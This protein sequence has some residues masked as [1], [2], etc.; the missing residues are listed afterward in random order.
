[1][2]MPSLFVSHGSPLLLL[3]PCPARDFLLGAG[4]ALPKPSAVLCVSAHWCSAGPAVTGAE[5]PQQIYDFR[6]F[7]QVLYEQTYAARG[8]AALAGDI[9]QLLQSSGF[10]TATDRHRGL[11]HGA[12]VPL[13]LMYPDASVPVL[14]LS[15]QP[16]RDPAWHLQLGRAL[17]PLRD[18]G[19][20]ILAS[21]SL[22][23]NLYE[24]RGQPI[25]MPPFGWVSEFADWINQ[26]LAA[27]DTDALLGAMRWA[28]AAMENHPTPEHLL[29]LY[30]ALG[31][32]GAA[33][34][35]WRAETLHR[36][37][38]YGILAMDAFRFDGLA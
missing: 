21:G 29:P 7:P 37:Y 14:Q 28:P 22:T 2:T 11:D 20:L 18:R 30:V 12:W 38:T 8:D 32:A 31:A 16:H 6:G 1:M 25:D 33:G 24:M 17:A 35:A 4:Q 34:S 23:H 26:K 27:G 19:V 13:K 36:S 5:L 3:T 10:E 9:A 15:V